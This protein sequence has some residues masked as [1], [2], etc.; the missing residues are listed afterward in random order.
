MSQKISRK[1]GKQIIE[2]II[3]ARHDMVELGRLHELDPQSLAGWIS[4]PAN[5][6]CLAG[7]CVLADLQTQLLLS[8]YRTV[9][10]TRL[11]KLATE[12]GQGDVARRAC[13]DL[14]RADLK[15]AEMEESDPDEFSDEPVP[16]RHSFYR[17]VQPAPA[18]GG[19][20]CDDD[21]Q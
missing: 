10:A 14:L 3:N 20:A 21:G 12:E 4:E 13:M 9:A 5:H 2:D 11:I 8:R 16:S 7:L 18:A 17:S 15:R 6:R 1:K 19:E